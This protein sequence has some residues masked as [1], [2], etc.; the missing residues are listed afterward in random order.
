MKKLYISQIS[1]VV[2]LL[3]LAFLSYFVSNKIKFLNKDDY[4]YTGNIILENKLI[5]VNVGDDEIIYISGNSDN[6]GTACL[7][8]N[9]IINYGTYRLIDNK[10]VVGMYS[11]R[12]NSSGLPMV[13]QIAGYT[14]TQ[15]ADITVFISG[16]EFKLALT[17]KPQLYTYIIEGGTLRGDFYLSVDA[18]QGKKV[19][20]DQIIC[21]YYPK[22]YIKKLAMGTYSYSYR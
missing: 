4:F 22:Q 9:T 6:L 11:G 10:E 7:S 5:D 12:I 3:L 8:I 2:S 19:Y 21:A 17:D 15:D 16:H 14:D 1:F 18:A 13:V 20:I